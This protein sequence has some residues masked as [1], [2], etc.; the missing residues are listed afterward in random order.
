MKPHYGPGQS[1]IDND[2]NLH[3]AARIVAVNLD[4]DGPSVDFED[5]DGQVEYAVPFDLIKAHVPISGD[6]LVFDPEVT[7]VPDAVFHEHYRL[8]DGEPEPEPQP[9]PNPPPEP[10]P[11]PEPDPQPEPEV[12]ADK[13]Q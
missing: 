6:W 5:R 11:Q 8:A 2:G 7:I 9:E 10:E 1:Y 12:E 13:S 3:S 4:P